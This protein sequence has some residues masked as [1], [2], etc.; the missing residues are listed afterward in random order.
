MRSTHWE[1]N[2]H[3]ID[4]T[5]QIMWL[6]YAACMSAGLFNQRDKNGYNFMGATLDA[7]MKKKLLPE[8]CKQS[9]RY[10]NDHL[11]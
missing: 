1:F 4:I 8:M 10:S 7:E 3:R 9:I 2:Q 11:P 6:E 5:S